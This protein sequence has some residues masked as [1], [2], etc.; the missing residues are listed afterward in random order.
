MLH[1]RIPRSYSP[2]SVVEPFPDPSA[3]R[4]R[5]EGNGYALKNAAYAVS[6][7]W[8]LVNP[9]LYRIAQT[10]YPEDREYERP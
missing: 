9:F 4:D 7:A 5:M 8:V 10:H 2:L 6:G 1:T 3:K